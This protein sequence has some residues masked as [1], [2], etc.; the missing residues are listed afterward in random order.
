MKI[1]FLC[2]DSKHPVN[3]YLRVWASKNYEAHEISIVR[4]KKDIPGGD[5][6]FLISC[7]EILDRND[8]SRYRFSLVLHAS[9]LPEGK[10]W[11]PHIWQ[12]VEG[13]DELVLSMIEA[14]DEVDSGRI[15][16]QKSISVPKHYLWNEVNQKL[17]E[18]E[19]DL[20][21]KAVN[22]MEAIVPREQDSMVQPTYYRKRTPQDSEINPSKS[23]SSQFDLIRVCEPERYPAYFV[24]NGHKYRLI[25][26]KIND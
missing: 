17:F 5:F 25:L 26:E 1:T 20:I 21:D 22:S 10:G 24:L 7:S 9:D 15:W 11:S 2:S 19:I 18:A 4:K 23:I 16:L 3:D 6:L 14:E 13:R 8:R 12:I